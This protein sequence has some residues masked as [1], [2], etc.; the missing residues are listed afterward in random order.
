MNSENKAEMRKLIDNPVSGWN[1]YGIID[2]APD[3]LH[4]NK[5]MEVLYE[6]MD[7]NPIKC[8]AIYVHEFAKEPYFEA[9]TG[10]AKTLRLMNVFAYR[11]EE[12]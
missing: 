6:D 1:R 10:A 4:W 11:Y 8:K 3:V 7:G 5:E 12:D 9:T 2:E